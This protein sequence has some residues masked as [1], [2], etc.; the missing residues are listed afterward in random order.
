MM[1]YNGQLS[2]QSGPNPITIKA[3]LQVSRNVT[4]TLSSGTSTTLTY[5]SG[6]WATNELQGCAVLIT[7]GSGVGQYRYI[8][9]NTQTVITVLA[10]TTSATSGAP[11]SGCT[12]EIFDCY[13]ATFNGSRTVTLDPL[14]YTWTDPISVYAQKGAKI[15][16]HTFVQV[17]LGGSYPGNRKYSARPV[18]RTHDDSLP[19]CKFFSMEFEKP[20]ARKRSTCSVS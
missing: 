15:F 5:P 14:T 7:S 13:K 12:I 3:G 6:Q 11:M 19:G 18:P 17:P 20:K 1:Y 8:T 10:F 9:S 16:Y 4:Y 2:E